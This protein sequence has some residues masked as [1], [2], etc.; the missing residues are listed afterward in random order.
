[1]KTIRRILI[2]LTVFA[3][4]LGMTYVAVNAGSS[5]ASTNGPSFEQ[6][7]RPA[8]PNGE[9]PEFRGENGVGLIFGAIK[10]IAVISIIVAVVVLPKGW[11]QKGRRAIQLASG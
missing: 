7:D 10:N 9:R 4:V 3:L 6:S 2:I 11:I 5:S 1:M 8:F